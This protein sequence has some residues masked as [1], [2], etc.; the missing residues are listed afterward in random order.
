MKTVEISLKEIL[1]YV[2]RR[3]KLILAFTLIFALLVGGYSFVQMNSNKSPEAADI[4]NKTTT[5]SYSID[6][7]MSNFIAY[8][9]Y[10][11]NQAI[12]DITKKL[13]ERYIVIAQGA[14]LAEILKNIVPAGLVEAQI[15]NFVKVESP[16][17]GIVN[18]SATVPVGIDSNKVTREI[19]NYLLGQVESLSQSIS[20][21]TLSV[22]ASSVST[23][24][25]T[26]FKPRNSTEFIKFTVM[27]LLIGLAAGLLAVICIYLIKLP[28]QTPAQIQHQLGIKYLG[29]IQ[30]KKRLSLG[31][32]LAG[33]LRMA[34]EGKAMKIISANLREFLSGQKRILVTGTVSEDY[35]K[36][37]SEQIAAEFKN[38]DIIFNHGEDINKDADTIKKLSASDAVI[39][40]ERLDISKFRHIN[41]EKERLDM[42]G[43]AILGYVLY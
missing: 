13:Q 30:R 26:F 36:A 12:N 11:D 6:L 8:R 35:I 32:R 1:V 27:G 43:T 34:D 4:A 5:L 28:V 25:D 22:L 10:N 41:E 18:I 3:W 31:D 14:P 33:S 42:S 29:G 21:H 16:S 20:A 19:Y 38:D 37:F 2:L 24:T 23:Q 15:R 39:L 17:I 40:L 7:D 9:T